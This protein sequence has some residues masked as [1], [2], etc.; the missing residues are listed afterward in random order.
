MLARLF[1]T[2]NSTTLFV[3]IGYTTLLSLAQI[4]FGEKSLT[5]LQWLGNSY[6]VKPFVPALAIVTASFLLVFGYQWL[7][8]GRHKLIRRNMLIPAVILPF[9]L[10]FVAIGSLNLII[11]GMFA[12]FII[13]T[14]LDVFHGEGIFVRA[15]NT[16]LLIGLSS[17]FD[18]SMMMLLPFTYL[19]FLVFGRLNP[20]TLIIPWVGFASVWLNALALEY[21]FFNSSETFSLFLDLFSFNRNPSGLEADW[22]HAVLLSVMF[23]PGLS[24]YIQTLTRAGVMKR[25][26]QTA[27][28]IASG[29][30]ISAYFLLGY[31]G[32]QLAV[33]VPTAAILFSN[34]LQYVQRMWVR[35]LLLWILITGWIVV[36]L[37]FDFTLP[38]IP[39][40][41]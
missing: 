2:I 5:T 30:S 33:I 13:K 22:I 27:L 32:Y 28:I 14:W 25:Q 3:V 36:L 39:W 38:S 17:L 10:S 8:V 41:Y 4:F 23:F 18:G 20:R 24:E 12:F 40:L 26:T 29:L 34:F 9:F 7:I 16:G 19:V 31:G 35:E 21:L 37:N 1:S 15:L 6:I 11:S